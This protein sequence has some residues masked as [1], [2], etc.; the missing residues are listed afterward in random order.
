M[1]DIPGKSALIAGGTSGIGAAIANRLFAA[2]CHVVAAGLPQEKPTE[3]L[4][5]RIEI[6]GLDV[7]D[8]ESPRRLIAGLD[9]LDILVNSAGIIRRNAEFDLATFERVIDVNL[10]GT[11]RLCVACRPLLAERGG[12]IINVASMYSFFGSGQ[13][14]AY[15]ASKG[16]VAQLTKSLAVAWAP[17][18]IRVNAVAPGWIATPLTQV[19]QDDPARSAAILARTPLNRWGQPDDVAGAVIFLC[20]SLASF[21]TGVVLPVDGGYLIS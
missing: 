20:S 3:N 12:S 1:L 5:H 2:G 6:A 21:I 14:P 15:T 7:S 8:T 18:K 17:E 4:D 19:L 10:T 9:R 16:G 13:S 11:M